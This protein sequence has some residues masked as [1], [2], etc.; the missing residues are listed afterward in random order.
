MFYNKTGLKTFK[1]KDLNYDPQPHTYSITTICKLD[2]KMETV[3][4]KR[5]GLDNMSVAH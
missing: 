2:F 4:I 3:F 5:N 1:Y